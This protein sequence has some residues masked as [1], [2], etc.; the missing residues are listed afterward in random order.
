VFVTLDRKM[1]QIRKYQVLNN[2]MCH[3]LMS[4]FGKYTCGVP[5]IIGMPLSS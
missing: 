1:N 4:F 2:S 5:S 3:Q